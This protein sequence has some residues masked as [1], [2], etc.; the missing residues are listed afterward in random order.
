MRLRSSNCAAG[1]MDGQVVVWDVD[2]GDGQA[3][4]YPNVL[5]ERLERFT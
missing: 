3:S 1:G 2:E 5:S 4:E